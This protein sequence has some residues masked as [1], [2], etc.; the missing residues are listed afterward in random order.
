MLWILRGSVSIV[1]TAAAATG[2]PESDSSSPVVGMN[3]VVVVVV[4]ATIQ[5]EDPQCVYSSSKVR[6]ISLP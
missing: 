2:M 4:P 1:C 3:D 6:R 5:Q